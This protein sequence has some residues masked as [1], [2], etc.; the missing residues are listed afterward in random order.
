MTSEKKLVLLPVCNGDGL[1][2]GVY[3]LCTSGLGVP[4]IGCRLGVSPGVGD[5]LMVIALDP[6]PPRTC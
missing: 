2:D 3:I 5:D 4:P 1:L 6:E